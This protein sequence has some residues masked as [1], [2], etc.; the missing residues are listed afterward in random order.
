M[1]GDELRLT[2]EQ[3]SS[4]SLRPVEELRQ[5]RVD[6][7]RPYRPIE[8]LTVYE[9]YI[10][11]TN[12]EYDYCTRRIEKIHD[13]MPAHGKRASQYT[14]D[15]PLWRSCRLQ[16]YFTAKG[17][18]DYFVIDD[19]STSP[20]IGAAG[21]AGAAGAVSEPPTPGSSLLISPSSQEE[22]KL[23]EDLKADVIRA[24]RDVEEKA[25]VVEGIDESRADRVPWLIHTG[26]PT[27]LRGL[28]DTEIISSY[29]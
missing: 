19:P 7:K 12:A 20:R 21:A 26:F 29:A 2:I 13:H 9:G 8:G 22:G 3:L 5:W 4:Y 17:L 14:D 11:C 6:R 28:R 27:H 16:T 15:R 1:R 25:S 24:S 10:C 18:I 23:F